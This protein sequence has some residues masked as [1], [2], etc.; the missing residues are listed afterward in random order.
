MYFYLAN[1][2]GSQVEVRET[3]HFIKIVPSLSSVVDQGQQNVLDCSLT[4]FSSLY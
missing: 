4:F 1:P 3:S 2:G